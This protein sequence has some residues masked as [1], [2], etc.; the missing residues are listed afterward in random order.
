MKRYCAKKGVVVFLVAGVLGGA[1]CPPGRNNTP[2]NPPVQP[3]EAAWIVLFD[4]RGMSGWK[5]LQGSATCEGGPI[6]L[7][8]RKKD[9]TIVARGV[10]LKNGTVE[11]ELVRKGPADG[12]GPYTVALRLPVR[13]TWGSIYFVC[14]PDNVEACR[15]T[16][17]ERFPPPEQKARFEKTEGPETWRFVM[18]DRTIEC[19]RLGRKIL[20]YID[21]DPRGGTIG[22]TASRC[23]IELL[24]VRYRPAANVP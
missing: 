14:R 8:G 11:V 9:T 17:R 10:N 21:R 20:S 15:A 19:Y 1:G 24:S 16:W 7:D 12:T 23:R 2:R 18:K 6:I 13:I 4:G 22:I 5:V 3:D